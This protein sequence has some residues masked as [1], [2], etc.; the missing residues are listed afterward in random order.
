[1]ITSKR[2]AKGTVHLLVNQHLKAHKQNLTADFSLFFV[3][4][5]TVP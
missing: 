5:M 2:A 1:M 3:V 4:T